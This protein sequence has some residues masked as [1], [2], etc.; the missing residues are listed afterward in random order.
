MNAI[1]AYD[2][3]TGNTETCAQW[4]RDALTEAGYRVDL[5]EAE[6]L[7]PAS[8]R[9]YDLIILGCPTYWNG[10]VTEGFWTLLDRMIGMDLYG[11]KVAVFGLGDSE[12][13]PDVFC[14]SV[15]VVEDRLSQCGARLAVESLRFDGEPE[16]DPDRVRRWAGEII[17]ET[18]G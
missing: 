3:I 18:V 7:D 4:I 13:Y 15:D 2:T 10:D 6:S 5:E 1:I 8:L 14:R 16:D 17:E 12:S 9:D 11:K